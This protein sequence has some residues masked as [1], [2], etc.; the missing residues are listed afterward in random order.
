MEIKRKSKRIEKLTK[1]ILYTNLSNK[2]LAFLNKSAIAEKKIYLLEEFLNL[3]EGKDKL[4]V[5][6]EV[7]ESDFLLSS[8]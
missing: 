2:N 1:D 6:E 4:S 3:F 8:D 7:V 5:M